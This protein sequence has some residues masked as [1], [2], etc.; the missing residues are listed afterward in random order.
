MRGLR[1]RRGGTGARAGSVRGGSLSASAVSSLSP[2]VVVSSSVVV[3]VV[4]VVPSSV[5]IIALSSVVVEVVL[6]SVVSGGG[7]GLM[8][9][10]MVVSRLRAR[11]KV[12]MRG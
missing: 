3:V 2:I 6:S 10:A 9:R 1:E 11:E 5:V 7:T 12:S 4:V 8:A